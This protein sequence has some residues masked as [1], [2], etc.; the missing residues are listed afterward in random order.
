ML[1]H[2]S[3][4]VIHEVL[5]GVLKGVLW[6]RHHKKQGGVIHAVLDEP[7]ALMERHL[8]LSPRETVVQ[9]EGLLAVIVALVEDIQM[10]GELF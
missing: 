5:K 9:E 7:V 10:L 1:F 4:K 8:P 6:V 2:A 3:G